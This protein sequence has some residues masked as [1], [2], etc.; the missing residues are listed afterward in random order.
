[1]SLDV[2]F[3]V[4]Y[5]LVAGVVA[6]LTTVVTGGE[7]WTSQVLLDLN[8]L[9]KFDWNMLANAQAFVRLLYLQPGNPIWDGVWGLVYCIPL[10]FSIGISWEILKLVANA[11]LGIFRR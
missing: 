4:G 6:L 3:I 7:V 10:F 1:M 11:V 5:L 8:Q 2:F 9:S